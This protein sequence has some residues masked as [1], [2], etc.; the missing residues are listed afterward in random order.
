MNGG[1]GRDVLMGGSGT[2][3]LVGGAGEDLL[4]APRT[5]FTNSSNVFVSYDNDPRALRRI[6]DEWNRSDVGYSE[7]FDHITGATTGGLNGS[8]RLRD[9]AT[10]DDGLR[11]VL[12]G[13]AD[14]DIFFY[15]RPTAE[16]NQDD[17]RD[18]ADDERRVLVV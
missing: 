6:H 5:G 10:A 2:D 4:F 15:S 1:A 16:A 3:S 8:I 13:D 18:R 14:R 17:L 11:D 12:R 9:K 7:R